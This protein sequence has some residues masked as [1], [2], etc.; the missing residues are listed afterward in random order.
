MQC[1]TIL[2]AESYTID[3]QLKDRK[4]AASLGQILSRD[5]MTQ[6]SGRTERKNRRNGDEPVR[7]EE[8]MLRIQDLLYFTSIDADVCR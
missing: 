8:W 1:L 4:E 2:T 5:I 6:Q 7:S 3:G